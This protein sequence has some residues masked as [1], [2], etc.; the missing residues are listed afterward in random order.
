[1]KVL[2]FLFIILLLVGCG[3]KTDDQTQTEPTNDQT[4]QV[5]SEEAM[6]R[7]ASQAIV[8]KFGSS[9]K[10]ELVSAMSDGGP[11]NAVNVCEIKAP[12][13]ADQYSQN[14]FVIKRVSD[15][16]RNIDNAASDHEKEILAKFADAQ[17]SPKYFDETIEGDSASSYY[18]YQPIRVNKLC[19]NCHGTSDKIDSKVKMALRDKYP[20]DMAVD[21]Q[22]GD[23]RG[24]FVVEASLPD[25]YEYAK[26]LAADTTM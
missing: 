14:G 8:K 7:T 3:S 17:N 12:E 9:L 21:Y 25:A 1:M 16:N 18:Y 4:A 5:D 20:D 2:T 24:M 6:L 19:L 13:I 23:L 11:S 26:T 10:S 15:K 22:D